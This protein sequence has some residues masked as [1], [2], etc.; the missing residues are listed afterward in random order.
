M[1]RHSVKKTYLFQA[2]FRCNSPFCMWLISNTKISLL[3]CAE[4]LPFPRGHE[5]VFVAATSGCASTGAVQRKP[6]CTFPSSSTWRLKGGEEKQCDKSQAQPCQVCVASS[7]ASIPA[8]NQ[9]LLGLAFEIAQSKPKKL[10]V[11]NT[12][13]N[14]LSQNWFKVKDSGH[15]IFFQEQPPAGKL[16]SPEGAQGGSWHFVG[17]SI[18]VTCHSHTQTFI[19]RCQ[20][21]SNR[22][23]CK[24]LEVLGT[25]SLMSVMTFCYWEHPK[26]MHSII[27]MAR[28]VTLRVPLGVCNWTGVGEDTDIREN[29]EKAGDNLE[30]VKITKDSL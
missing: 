20:W 29:N 22:E 4:V 28:D 10:F 24:G 12:V 21:V 7:E 11:I 8:Q 5:N 13:K 15:F 16:G 23:Y 2:C 17:H 3:S 9:A 19:S 25:L 6:G 1:V 26:S 30:T 27:W 14:C 18:K